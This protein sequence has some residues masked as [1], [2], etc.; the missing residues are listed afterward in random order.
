MITGIMNTTEYNG[1]YVGLGHKRLSII[2]IE[3]GKQPITN[4]DGQDSSGI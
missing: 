3:S 1:S 2:D 4:E